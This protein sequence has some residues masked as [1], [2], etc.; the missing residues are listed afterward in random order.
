MPPPQEFMSRVE[1]FTHKDMVDQQRLGD[2][3]PPHRIYDDISAAEE[4][5][6]LF[7]DGILRE[8]ADHVA[9]HANVG[10]EHRGHALMSDK[11]TPFRTITLTPLKD[12]EQNEEEMANAL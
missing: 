12:W 1:S 2:P 9:L 6:L 10:V 11:K 8:I 3:S 7:L 4:R 5:G